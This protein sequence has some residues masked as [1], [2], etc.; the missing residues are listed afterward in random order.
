MRFSVLSIL[1]KLYEAEAKE[2]ILPGEDGEVCVMDFHD[3]FLCRLQKGWIKA[4]IENGKGEE[5]IYI[6]DGVA[7]M[8]GNELTVLAEI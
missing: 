1:D 7:R 6:K 2:V 3:P 5:E 4:K 8:A